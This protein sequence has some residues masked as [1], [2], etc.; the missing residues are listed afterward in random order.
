[1]ESFRVVKEIKYISLVGQE[2]GT[3]LHKPKAFQF[4]G[5]DYADVF[6]YNVKLERHQKES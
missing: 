3:P 6:L 5:I 2:V 4:A 1:M